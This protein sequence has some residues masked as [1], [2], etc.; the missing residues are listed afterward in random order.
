MN[1]ILLLIIIPSLQQ[2]TSTQ[3]FCTQDIPSFLTRLCCLVQALCQSNDNKIN[4]RK[5]IIS[6]RSRIFLQAYTIL[7]SIDEDPELVG[8]TRLSISESHRL[9]KCEPSTDFTKSKERTNYRN[10]G[11]I[12]IPTNIVNDV[13]KMGG[14]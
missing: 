2:S 6:S 13:L 9:T 3:L 7:P 4:L 11:R 8:F 12:H 1:L 5:I 10:D 14:K